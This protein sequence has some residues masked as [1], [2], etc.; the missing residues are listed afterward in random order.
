MSA[1]DVEVVRSIRLYMKCLW[2]VVDRGRRN[3]EFDKNQA[4]FYYGQLR[5]FVNVY[6]ERP[7]AELDTAQVW[8]AK[9]VLHAYQ[10]LVPSFLIA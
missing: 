5:H 8:F 9:E 6:D 2:E 7:G 1:Y 10:E 3:L 4:E